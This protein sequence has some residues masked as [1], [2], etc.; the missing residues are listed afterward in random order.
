VN[1]AVFE[2]FSFT[3]WRHFIL[4]SWHARP[5]LN[6]SVLKVMAVLRIRTNKVATTMRYIYKSTF[7]LLTYLTCLSSSGHPVYRECDVIQSATMLCSRIQRQRHHH[8]HMT[9]GWDVSYLSHHAVSPLQLNAHRI[10]LVY[11]TWWTTNYTTSSF[12][13]FVI[14]SILP[15]ITS[16]K[17]RGHEV[18]VCPHLSV[19]LS[20]CLSLCLLARLL[21][22]ACMDLDEM[23]RVDGCRDMDEVNNFWARS[24]L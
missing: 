1:R 3:R 23:L 21:K 13:S 16:D 7:Y 8:G 24:G 19:C 5:Q 15:V 9:S 4:H 10:R 18:C 17:G 11:N 12:T 22:N 14:I 20:V 2:W 6:V